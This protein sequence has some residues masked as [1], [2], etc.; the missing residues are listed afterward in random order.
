MAHKLDKMQKEFLWQGNRENKT[1]DLVNWGVVTTEK[2]QGNRDGNGAGQGRALTRHGRGIPKWG[3][4][5]Q[6]G[7]KHILRKF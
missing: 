7:S 2:R 3:R 5:G 1:F 4:V 6:R